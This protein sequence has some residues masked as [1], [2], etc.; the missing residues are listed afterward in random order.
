VALIAIV[1]FRGLAGET[2]NDSPE[3]SRR[4]ERPG[5]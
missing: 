1:S 4:N 5:S 3:N 2:P